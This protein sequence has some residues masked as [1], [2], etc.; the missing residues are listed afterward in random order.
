MTSNVDNLR[1][2]IAT[3]TDLARGAE[4]TDLPQL[5]KMHEHIQSLGRLGAELPENARELFQTLCRQVADEDERIILDECA[6]PV[7]AL[8]RIRRAV[9]RLG[10]LAFDESG[11]ADVA[12][13]A[14]LV[15]GMKATAAEAP[16]PEPA[17]PAAE[18]PSP[19][20]AAPT[21]APKAFE[22]FQQEP[23][24]ISEQEFEYINSFLSECQEH[25][26]NVE[27][28]LL[29]LEQNPDDLDK[30]NELF[31]PFHTIKGMAGFLNL[32]DINALTHAAENLLDL[33]RKGKLQLRPQTIDLIFETLDV[34][35]VQVE[36]VGQYVAAPNGQP[37]PQP[38]I[39]ALLYRIHEAAQDRPISPAATG[40]SG[41][42]RRRLGEILSEDEGTSAALVGFA[43]E[44]QRGPMAGKQ[45]GQILTETGA[46]TAREVGQALRKQRTHQETSIRVDTVKLDNL[47]NMVGELVIAQ[48]QV[49][50][51]DSQRNSG[52]TSALVEQVSKITRDVQEIAMSL[53]MIPIAQTFHKMARVSRDIARKA[54]KVI[55]FIIEGEET[56]LDKN[57]IQEISDPL[58]HM[59]RNAVDHGVEAP[60]KRATLGKPQKGIV[61]ISAYHQ[62]GNIVIEVSDD[63]RGLDKDVL[64]KKGIEKGLVAPDAQLSEQQIYQLV[65]APGFSTAEKV[66]D[67]SGRG[68][69][70]DVVKRNI[71]GLRGKVEIQSVKGQ[72]TTFIIRLPLTLAVIDGMVVR[73]GSQ[74]FIIPTLT[75]QQALVPTREQITTVQ[76]RG[77]MLN[78]RDKLYPLIALGQAFN[79][80]EAVAE[81][82]EGM[83]VILQADSQTYGI[84]LDDLLGQ[85]QVVI[86]T[87][88]NHFREIKGISGGAILGD[89]SIGLIIEPGGLMELHQAA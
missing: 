68:V 62:G 75:I 24:L 27:G 82:T 42:D 57:V 67:I 44:Q 19:G 84:V 17:A 31:R 63:G 41:G 10:E 51:H 2:S 86:K 53:R 43:L 39:G 32:R 33:A 49:A 15:E 54:S 50:Q 83:V 45:I 47:V 72:G 59:V 5:A 64:L 81:P 8:E 34:L 1:Q 71:E 38:P 9:E 69:G 21:E 61:K 58:L 11:A 26:E 85:Q 14:E 65:M 55:D 22:D 80:P 30:V 23:L 70:M 7:A 74:K 3:L 36:M 76:G 16:A 18:A 4:P 73:A 12:L 35:K 56:E 89:G 20:P 66:T 40:S 52:R 79:I 77:R 28:V 13:L 87:L 25:I 60:D 37:V 48:A 29:S 78:L 88:G 46:A 6:D